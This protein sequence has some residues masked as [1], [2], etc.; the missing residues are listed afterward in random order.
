MERNL[1]WP[2]YLNL[3]KEFLHLAESIHIDDSQ[4]NVYS[5]RIA[6]LLIRTVVEFES[7]AKSLYFSNG[8]AKADDNDLYFDTDCMAYLVNIWDIDKKVV[9]VSSPV[10]FFEK[11]E[12]IILTPLHKTNKRGTSSADWCKAYQAVKHNR[13]KDLQ[14]GNIKNL[15]RALAA[16]YILNLYYRDEKVSFIIPGKEPLLDFSFGSQIFSVMRPNNISQVYIDGR[17][18]KGE[19]FEKHVYVAVPN[20]FKYNELVTLMNKE[21]DETQFNL[22]QNL[23]SQ[24]KAG[25]VLPT[26]EDISAFLS[27]ER[28]RVTNEVGQK[29]AREVGLKFMEMSYTAELNK[30]QTWFNNAAPAK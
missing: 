15:I 16:L 30:N 19:D 29:Y 4:I 23:E 18:P 21:N 24:I 9:M 17:Y 12:N 10:L 22:I 20:D 13:V 5:V 26:K 2:V 11:E 27:K 25:K 6:E 1:Y 7:L 3:E 8:G 14:K 28:S